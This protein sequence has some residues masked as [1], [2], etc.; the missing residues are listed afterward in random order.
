MRKVFAAT[1]ALAFLGTACDNSGGA[2]AP[3]TVAPP[4][5]TETFTG[6]VEPMSFVFHTFTVAQFGEIDITLTAAG[7]PP[8]IFMGLGIGTPTGTTCALTF[9]NGT[10]NVQAG[11]TPHIVGTAAAGPFCVAVYDIGNQ[12]ATV[13]YAVTVAHS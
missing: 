13:T 1:L 4:L 6:T 11:T 3:T 8:T 5:T 2:T 9:Q 12:M 7:P 10:V